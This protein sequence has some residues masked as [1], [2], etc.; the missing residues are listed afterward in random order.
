MANTKESNDYYE[1]IDVD[2]APEAAGYWTEPVSIRK[3]RQRLVYFS[4][5]ES[6]VAT[7]TLQYKCIGDSDWTDFNTYTNGD[8]ENRFVVEGSGASV[9][10]R[11]GIKQADYSSGTIRLGFDW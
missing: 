5:R 10:W 4:M 1:Y 3:E 8:E 2:A 9:L 11:A 6:G 7:I